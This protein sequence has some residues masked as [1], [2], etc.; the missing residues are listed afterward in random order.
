LKL[1]KVIYV[2]FVLNHQKI[3]YI[4]FVIVI[5]EKFWNDISDWIAAKYRINFRLNK[6]HKL[7]GFQDIVHFISLLMNYF[8]V[9]DFYLTAVNIRMFILKR[10]NYFNMINIV[11][12]TEYIIA[13]ETNKLDL[14]YEKW[15]AL[16]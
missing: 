11:I 1:L 4:C 7:L 6:S 3:Y 10:S 12:K 5:V 13:K 9:Q 8:G 2:Y 14:H 16:I 15:R